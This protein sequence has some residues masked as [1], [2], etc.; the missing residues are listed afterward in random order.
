LEQAIAG[1]NIAAS[2][3]LEKGDQ[4]TSEYLNARATELSKVLGRWKEAF[5]TKPHGRDRDHSF[6]L[7]CHSSLET[8]LGQPITYATLANLVSA[9]YKADGS[10]PEKPITEEHIRK[11]LTNF[12]RNVPHWH[13]YSSMN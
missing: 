8:E 3:Y 5:A 9:G 6:L 7:V 11:N 12:K 1:L 2:L 13:L 10:P 4:A